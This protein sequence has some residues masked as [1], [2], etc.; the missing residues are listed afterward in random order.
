MLHITYWCLSQVDLDLTSTCHVVA[1]C[2]TDCHFLKIHV[3]Y[4]Y[5]T[6]SMQRLRGKNLEAYNLFFPVLY[7]MALHAYVHCQS[8]TCII[9]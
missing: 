1:L 6:N 4:V 9:R 8:S 3:M 2:N 5:R 7:I